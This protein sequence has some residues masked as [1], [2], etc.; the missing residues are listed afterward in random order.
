L[1]GCFVSEHFGQARP[2]YHVCYASDEQSA[3]SDEGNYSTDFGFISFTRP[4]ARRRAVSKLLL[5]NFGRR[6]FAFTARSP[7]WFLFGASEHNQIIPPPQQ[8]RRRAF[9]CSTLQAKSPLASGWS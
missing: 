2:F 8:N 4:C 3:G 7:A 5:I 6:R 1:E 9:G